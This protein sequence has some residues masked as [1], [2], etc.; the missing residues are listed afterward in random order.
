MELWEIKCEYCSR[1]FSSDVKQRAENDLIVH[2]Q[3]EHRGKHLDQN[4]VDAK[5]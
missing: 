5:H 3:D 2:H 4:W 1:I